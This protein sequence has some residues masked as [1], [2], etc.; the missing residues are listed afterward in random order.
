[1][2]YTHTHTHIIDRD[3]IYYIHNRSSPRLETIGLYNNKVYFLTR[4]MCWNTVKNEL[5][6]NIRCVIFVL[7]LQQNFGESRLEWFTTAARTIQY[8]TL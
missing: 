1:M 5:K 8:L 4:H 3:K 2:Y 7:H 6:Y